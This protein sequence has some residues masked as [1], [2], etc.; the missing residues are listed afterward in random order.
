[1]ARYFFVNLIVLFA[2]VGFCIGFVVVEGMDYLWLGLNI[3]FVLIVLIFQIIMYCCI[4]KFPKFRY[5]SPLYYTLITIFTCSG[6]IVLD[7][8]IFTNIFGYD[9]VSTD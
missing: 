9:S 4:I 1:L 2:Y 7:P 8:I 6:I 5:R 3:A